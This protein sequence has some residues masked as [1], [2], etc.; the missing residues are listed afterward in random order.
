MR[1][2]LRRANGEPRNERSGGFTLVEIIVALAI[3]SLSLAV[4]FGSLSDSFLHQ[5]RAKSLLEA[6][7]IA[8]SVLAQIGTAIPLREGQV[9]GASSGAAYWV[10]D[11]SAFGTPADRD[12]WQAAPYRIS[13]RVFDNGAA[14]RAA[15]TLTTLRFSDNGASQ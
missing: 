7:R 3:L 1:R 12:V 8:R 15:V 4:L 10:V 5:R 9:K 2:R 6:T 14:Q 13:V 11:I